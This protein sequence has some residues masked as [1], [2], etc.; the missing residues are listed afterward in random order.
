MNERAPVI[1]FSFSFSLFS[2]KVAVEFTHIKSSERMSFIS[3]AL[4]GD[5]MRGKLYRQEDDEMKNSLRRIAW[6]TL[7]EEFIHK[8]WQDKRYDTIGMAWIE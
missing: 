4:E 6:A 3:N 2:N 1:L 5:F 8:K 7:F